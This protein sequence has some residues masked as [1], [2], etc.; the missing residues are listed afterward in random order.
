MTDNLNKTRPQ[1]ASKIN[2]NEA[3]E[4]RYWTEALGVT[5]EQL[6]KTV[7]EVGTS[8]AAVKKALKK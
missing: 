8:A 7:K 4:V 3:H 5:K 2:V 6:V 1:D